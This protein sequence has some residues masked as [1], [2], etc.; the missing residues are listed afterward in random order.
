MCSPRRGVRSEHQPCTACV[1]ASV[2]KLAGRQADAPY[3]R[4][5]WWYNT[6]RRLS[7]CSARR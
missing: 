2:Q 3:F 4:I 5:C 6:R 7:C 1:Q